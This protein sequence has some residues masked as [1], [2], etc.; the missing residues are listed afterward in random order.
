[1]RLSVCI[2]VYR[3]ERDIQAC[4]RSLFGQTLK[5]DVEFI[6][7]DDATDD[8]SVEIVRRT[9]EDYPERAEQVRILRHERNRGLVAARKTAMATAT[10]DY[11]IHC[12][13]DDW[14][15][16]TLYER[17]LASADRTGADLVHCPIVRENP[18][19]TRRAT[20]LPDLATGNALLSV[21]MPSGEFNSLVNKM[22]RRERVLGTAVEYPDGIDIG[23][24]LLFTAQV[25]G[26]CGKVVACGDAAYHYRLKETS[27]SHAQA[28]SRKVRDLC[29]VY[30]VLAQRLDAM[31]FESALDRLARDILLSAIRYRAMSASDYRQWRGRLH[32]GL[33][34]D[35]RHG[36]VKR[37]V[38]AVAEVSYPLACAL[39]G[40]LLGLTKEKIR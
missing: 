33:L 5:R 38:L 11:V 1:M 14:V 8:R 29:A 9:L 21:C 19:G 37:S 34:S 2:P 40:I 12:D 28:A 13:A 10:G 22:Y 32:G 20:A 23:E 30:E 16:E 26:R 39:S 18:D 31:P 7:V 17:M 3:V 24:D 6:F 25:I 35:G 15:D 36:V 4:A 27:M